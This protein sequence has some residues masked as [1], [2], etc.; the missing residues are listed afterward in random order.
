MK[1]HAADVV[2]EILRVLSASDRWL[3]LMHEKP[4]GDTAGCAIALSSLGVRIGKDV[5]LGCPE[6]FPQ[7]YLFMLR[8][9][10]H[11]VLDRIPDDFSGERCVVVSMDTS[12]P[13]RAVSGIEEARERCTVINIDHHPDN[14]GYGHINWVVPTASAT[15]EMVTELLAGSEWGISPDEA[16]ALYAAIVTD[17]GNFCFPSSSSQSHECAV[18]LVEAGAVPGDIAEELETNLS[19]NSLKLWGRVFERA[20]VF[21]DGFC[22]VFWI[23]R[24]DFLETCTTRQD[25]ENLVNFLLRIKGVKLAAL[26][27]EGD[28]GVRVNL[29]SRFPMNAREVAARFGGGGHVLASGCTIREPLKDALSALMAEME[30][31]ASSCLPSNK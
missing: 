16:N 19:V 28:D 15:G 23:A 12:N 18:I 8:G 4:D 7:K 5:I 6:Q 27:G 11:R 13:E 29:R 25:T 22:A 26:C 3:V 24:S 30:S 10:Q 1:N 20:T 14:T 9:I 17:N 2:S 31:H 21:S